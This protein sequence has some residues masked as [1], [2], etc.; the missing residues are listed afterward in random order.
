MGPQFSLLR[1]GLL[2]PASGGFVAHSKCS[3]HQLHC[4]EHQLNCH[5][6]RCPPWPRQPFPWHSVPHQ[7]ILCD[8]TCYLTIYHRYND[9][10]VSHLSPPPECTLLERMDFVSL[11]VAASPEPRSVLGTQKHSVNI[12]WMDELGITDSHSIN[13]I[14]HYRKISVIDLTNVVIE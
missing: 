12:W 9:V 14:K 5:L 1:K 7:T 8:P 10:I 3:G 4:S 13:I 2:A 11:S 6:T